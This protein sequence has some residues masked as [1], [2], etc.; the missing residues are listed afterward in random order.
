MAEEDKIASFCDATT[1]L[2]ERTK[3][4]PTVCED[5]RAAPCR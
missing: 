3:T 5:S 2:R 4:A 1:I